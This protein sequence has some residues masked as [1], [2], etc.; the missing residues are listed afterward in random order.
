MAI[1]VKILPPPNF[2]FWRIFFFKYNFNTTTNAGH[3]RFKNNIFLGR[4]AYL[5]TS[6]GSKS[7]FWAISPVSSVAILIKKTCCLNGLVV[8]YDK[9]AVPR[10]KKH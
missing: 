10:D 8:V 4:V 5:L 3:G 1:L 2:F 7:T 9:S 6:K